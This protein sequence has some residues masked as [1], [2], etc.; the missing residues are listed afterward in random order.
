MEKIKTKN[1]AVRLKSMLKVDF[2]RC[3]N[4]KLFYIMLGIALVMPI[5][6]LVMTTMMDG[7]VSVDPQTGVET[8][9]E[10]FK[11]VWEIIGSVSSGQQ[12]AETTAMGMGLTTM[13][14]I[15]LVFF[16]VAVFVCVF[17]AEDFRSGYSKNLFTVRSNKT[18]YIISKTVVCFTVG[19]SMIL[20]FFIGSMLG[21]AI[22]GLP[23]DL[24]GVNIE[25]II[26]CL[27]SKMLLVL[28]IVPIY[29]VMSIV[30]KQKLWLSILLSL[31][32][33]ALLFTMIPMITPL[34]STILNVVLCLV[35]GVMFSFGLGFVDKIL[36]TKRDIL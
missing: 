30:A 36:L 34:N 11:N 29:L 4:S 13:C 22:A 33:G 8:V 32:G 21:G 35:G 7:S 9:M 2:Q 31:A 19:A 23:F 6:I 20:A 17:V 26:M 3:F 10:G 16:A 14:N 5:L 27:L 25:N 18:D 12:T 24:V 28:A 15:N 1:F